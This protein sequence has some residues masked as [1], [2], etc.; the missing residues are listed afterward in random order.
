MNLSKRLEVSGMF[1]L[2]KNGK[3]SFVKGGQM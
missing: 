2:L 3:V 1:L